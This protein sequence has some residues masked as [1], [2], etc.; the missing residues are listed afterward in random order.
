MLL[1]SPSKHRAAGNIEKGKGF[2]ERHCYFSNCRQHQD[3]YNLAL[4][5]LRKGTNL[6]SVFF[7]N[8]AI[9]KV[10][11]ISGQFCRLTF[12]CLLFCSLLTILVLPSGPQYEVTLKG[13]VAPEDSGK[14]AIPSAA[15][16]GPGVAS[17]VPPI[18][19]NKQFVAWGGVTLGRAV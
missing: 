3:N 6:F 14:P 7:Q 12:S 4:L 9:A 15:L 5:Y 19:S 8:A 13:E 2:L 16:F 1:Q 10:F 17:D 11:H 18:L